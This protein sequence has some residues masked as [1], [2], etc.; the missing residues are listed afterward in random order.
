MAL[1]TICGVAGA[2]AMAAVSNIE[3]RFTGRPDSYIPAHTLAHLLHFADPDADRWTRN[4]AMHYSSGAIAGALRGLM[5]YANLRGPF[6][7]LMH[8][9][10]RLTFDQF[11]E[12]LTGVGAPPWTQ[13]RDELAIDLAEKTVFGLATGTLADALI[14]PSPTSSARRA[15]LGR[16]LRGFA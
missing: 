2:A 8:T 13:P 16:R 9:N 4:M 14:N 6:A 11:L 5:A 7:S 1:G 12:N 10:L 3:Q 15:Q